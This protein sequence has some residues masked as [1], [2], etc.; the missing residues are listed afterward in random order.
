MQRSYLLL[1][2][3]AQ[4]STSDIYSLARNITFSITVSSGTLNSTI[5]YHT[6]PYHQHHLLP[7][8]KIQLFTSNYCYQETQ[9]SKPWNYDLPGN[10]ITWSSFRTT[11]VG[12]LMMTISY[13]HPIITRNSAETLSHSS[14]VFSHRN[15]NYIHIYTNIQFLYWTFTLLI[16]LKINFAV[17]TE[18]PHQY[19]YPIGA[20]IQSWAM[21]NCT[22]HD[23]KIPKKCQ[24]RQQQVNKIKTRNDNYT[25]KQW[26]RHYSCLS[27]STINSH[28]VP[29]VTF[30]FC[31]QAINV[32]GMHKFNR[33]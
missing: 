1:Q 29:Y 32:L 12:L 7:T 8:H 23:V 24:G 18:L 15:S 6:I 11:T 25:D 28:S 22:M 20:R 30:E 14:L 10:S 5:P 26:C 16:P 21:H 3:M 31:K 19:V 4:W 27:H 17:D 2:L 9:Q 33:K 13:N